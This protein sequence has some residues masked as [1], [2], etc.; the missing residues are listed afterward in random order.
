[1]ATDRTAA[2]GGAPRLKIDNGRLHGSLSLKGGRI[3][4]VTL[5]DYHATIEQASPEIEL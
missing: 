3:D 2:L 1:M 4:D 5:A